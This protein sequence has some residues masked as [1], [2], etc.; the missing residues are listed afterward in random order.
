MREIHGCE[1][2]GSEVKAGTQCAHWHSPLDIIAIKFKCCGRWYSCF[3][4]HAETADHA[5]DV[6]PTAEF[7][8]KTILCGA[9]GYQM[10]V[11]EYL[12]CDSE[13]PACGSQ[14][15]PGCSK[16]HHLYFESIQRQT[17]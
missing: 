13:C 7:S 8:E 6:W 2:Y 10:T 14:F 5:A 4:C 11:T 17:K 15:N 12:A 3:D 9:C 16:H 1:I